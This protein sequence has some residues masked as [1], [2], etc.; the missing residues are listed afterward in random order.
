MARR[1]FVNG[2]VWNAT[3]CSG[4]VVIAT[5]DNAIAVPLAGAKPGVGSAAAPTAA[6][7]GA[8]KDAL[9]IGTGNGNTAVAAQA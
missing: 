5:A 6:T 8:W 9:T 1:S 7:S 2:P 3:Q 4:S